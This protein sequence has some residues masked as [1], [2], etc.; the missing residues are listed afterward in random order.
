MEKIETLE[1]DDKPKKKKRRLKKWVK[2]TFSI[3]TILIVFLAIVAIIL[4]FLLSGASTKSEV[5]DFTV[6]NGSSVYS[7]GK[8]LEKE[9]VIRS[10]IAYK[11]YVKVKN[12]KSYKAGVYRLDKSLKVKDIVSI[13]TGNYYKENGV[14]ITFKEGNT[15]TSIAK[16]I[17]KNTNVKESEFYDKIND[18]TY[19]DEL[20]NKY[21]FLT[22]DI[23]NDNI[24]YAL[25]GYLFPDTYS[26]T[27][28]VTAEKIIER[29]L[30]QT[31]KVFSKYRAEFSS[32]SYSINEIVALSS[33]VEKEG[34]YDKDRKMIAGVFY[35]R[36]NANMPLGS[37]VTTYY[38]NKIELGERDLTSSELNT[39]NP[40]NTRG[41]GM[42]GKLPVGAISNFGESSL[43]AV[44]NPDD[45]D[46]YYFVADKSGKTHFTKTY[47]EH[48]K[49]IKELKAANN[50]IEW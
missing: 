19:I 46:Y 14:K 4:S 28:D 18:E 7:V 41:P 47:A 15:I 22:D 8:K 38:A 35:N 10:Y 27:Y 9:G 11:T 2:V 24:Y 21:W 12:I 23:K 33:V 39:Y 37:D 29:M 50:W 13:L 44:L 40:Y 34:I 30:N 48:Q 36:L 5:V 1:K 31:N 49:I 17:A 3:L 20:I 32:S 43:K 45:N 26:F 16:E 25:E 6:D 42:N